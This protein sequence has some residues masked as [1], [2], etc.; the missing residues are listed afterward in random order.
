[1]LSWDDVA[2]APDAINW[3]VGKYISPAWN[4]PLP[5]R[6]YLDGEGVRRIAGHPM[7]YNWRADII[8]LIALP[9]GGVRK[10]ATELGLSVAVA[11]ALNELVRTVTRATREDD[12]VLTPGYRS[13]IWWLSWE[14]CRK[15]GYEH[16]YVESSGRHFLSRRAL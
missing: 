7:L 12:E 13:A 10:V 5:E 16:H 9:V 3:M 15:L 4:D 6:L 14:K 1:M 2:T 11:V 8:D